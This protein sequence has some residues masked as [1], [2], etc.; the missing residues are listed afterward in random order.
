[1][2]A[3]MVQN[4]TTLKPSTFARAVGWRVFE[5]KVAEFDIAADPVPVRRPSFWRVGFEEGRESSWTGSVI[6]RT[7]TGSNL[8]M[9]PSGQE[10][11]GTG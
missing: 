8:H 1:M 10:G 4:E 9:H 2:W 6:G 11:S 3:S 5:A 7:K